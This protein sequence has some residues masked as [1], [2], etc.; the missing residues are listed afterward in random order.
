LANLPPPHLPNPIVVNT[1]LI[2]HIPAICYC[3]AGFRLPLASS[4]SCLCS[5]STVIYAPRSLLPREFPLKCDGPSAPQLPHYTLLSHH[6]AGSAEYAV[7][8]RRLVLVQRACAWSSWLSRSGASPP[9]LL[10]VVLSTT[11][12]LATAVTPSRSPSPASS[13][14]DAVA[15]STRV[16]SEYRECMKECMRVVIPSECIVSIESV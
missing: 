8:V 15:P 2:S 9:A 14:T 1:C 6:Q 12:A 4:A 10:R 5:T 7:G 11:P 13:G 16:Y 3:I